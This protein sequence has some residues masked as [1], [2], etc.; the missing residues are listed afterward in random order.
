[1]KRAS[2]LIA[3]SLAVV[4]A[5]GCAT[6]PKSVS[7]AG[8]QVTVERNGDAPRVK[9]ELL[10]V[11]EDRLWIGTR[12]GVTEVPLATVRKVRVK[13]HSSDA[14]QALT[15]AVVGGLLT[16]GAMAGACASV[17]GNGGGTCAT[18]GLVLGGLW[19]AVGAL[20]APS[21]ESSSYLD[22]RKPA[23]D[24]LWPYSRL[25]QGLPEG[26]TSDSFGLALGSDEDEEGQ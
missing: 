18:V 19:L 13:R 16:G 25:P 9:G 8:R 23:P 12:D 24:E 10:V 26:L 3:T 2:R 11:Q 17:D 22:L 6:T 1:M 4:V 5:T 15:W 14:R 21:M 20:A 7:I